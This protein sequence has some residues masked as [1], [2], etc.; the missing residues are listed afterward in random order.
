MNYHVFVDN[1]N[2]WIEGQFASAVAK[3]LANNMSDAHERNVNDSTWRVDFGKLLELV[4]G[5]RVEDIKTAVLFGSKPPDNDSLWNIAKH[6]GFEVDCKTRNFSNKEKAVDTGMV[7]RID[8]CLYRQA[9]ADDIFVIVAGDRDFAP[10]VYAI[11]EENMSVVVAFW[12]NAANE[13]K[14]ATD[15]FINLTE[16]INYVRY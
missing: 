2:L 8:K 5:G 1:S 10:S 11:K 7:Q 15:S 9:Q 6:V 13:L 3:G 4:V 16:K 14:L 12:D